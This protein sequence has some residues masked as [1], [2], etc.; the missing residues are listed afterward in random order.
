MTERKKCLR[1][2][3]QAGFT[4]TETLLAAAV[5]LI[6][7]AVS[8]VA[9]VVYRNYLR[10]TELDHAAREIYMAA[11]NRAVLLKNR[12]RLETLVVEEGEGNQLSAGDQQYVY[13]R[14]NSASQMSELLPEGTIEPALRDGKFF[15]VYEPES[16][17]VT[18]VFFAGQSV[19]EEFDSEYY[20]RERAAS[21]RQRMRQTPMVGYYGGE[22]AAGGDAVTLRTPVINIM[23]EETLRAEI[24]WWIPQTLRGEKEDIR[25]IVTL[26]YGGESV[27]LS[28]RFS[29]GDSS[30][31]VSVSSE[32]G[33]VYIT[34]SST[35]LLDSLKEGQQFKDLGEAGGSGEWSDLGNDFTITAKVV[36]E[37]S[38][39]EN[40]RQVNG[41]EKSAKNNSLFAETSTAGTARV[42]NIRHLQNLHPGFS[43]AGPEK[44]RAVQTEDIRNVTLPGSG[45]GK[46]I[47]NFQ[48]IVNENLT[49]YNGGACKIQ[50]LYIDCAAEPGVGLFGRFGRG[51]M[52]YLEH[53]RLVN[54]VVRGEG[55]AAAGALC[56]AAENVFFTD[57]QVYWEIDSDAESDLQYRLGSTSEEKGYLLPAYQ[58]SGE[59]AGGLVGAGRNCGIWRCLA[60]TTVKGKK[61]AGGLVGR[62]REI[63]VVDSYADCYLTGKDAAGLIGMAEGTSNS[64]SGSYTAGFISVN[65]AGR[66]AGLYLSESPDAAA[67]SV[68]GSYAAM[69]YSSDGRTGRSAALNDNRFPL[70]NDMN[71]GHNGYTKTWY[72]F[73]PY[74]NGGEDTPWGDMSLDYE[75]LSLAKAQAG[76]G[77]PL[78]MEALFGSH[79]FEQIGV[80]R[81]HPC[82][83]QGDLSLD[84][85]PY[86]A[87]SGMEHYGDWNGLFRSGGLVYWE[88]YA[89]DDGDVGIYGGG[90]DTLKDS[91]AM[92]RDDGY[93]VTL[94][95]D[96]LGA[97]DSVKITFQYGEGGQEQIICRRQDLREIRVPAD[98][99]E[100]TYYLAKLPDHLICMEDAS[101]DFYRRLD[102]SIG[103]AAEEVHCFFNP[104]FAGTAM[105]NDGT[106]TEEDVLRRAENLTVK[107]RS[108]RHLY[109]LSRH[110]EYYAGSNQYV[111]LQ[112]LDLDYDVY[113]GYG[114]FPGRQQESIGKN[115]ADSF[116]NT[117]DG[118]SCRI[119]NV[120]LN[121]EGEYVGLFGYNRGTVRNM[122]LG[123]GTETG[124][125]SDTEKLSL[126]VTD[127]RTVYWGVLAGG[128]SGTITNCAVASD[129]MHM[130]AYG[131]SRVYAGGLVAVNYGTIMN[132]AAVWKK[133]TLEA[134][135]SDG[136][137][138]GFAGLNAGG[139]TIY[140]SYSMAALYASRARHGTVQAGGFAG[141]NGNVIRNS[142]AASSLTVSG[143][144]FAFGFCPDRTGNCYFLNN[145][146]FQYAGE[147][148]S[149]QYSDVPGGAEGQD[150]RQMTGSSLDGNTSEKLG[151][152]FAREGKRYQPEGEYE[153]WKTF[154]FP[155]VVRDG[156]NRPVHYGEWP[157]TISL[158]TLG[159]FYWEK[160][161]AY[162][163]RQEAAGQA[164]H[165]SAVRVDTDTGDVTRIDTLCREHDDGGVIESYGYGYFY[166]GDRP[167]WM[168][169]DVYR[170]E[171]LFADLE[172]QEA[173]NALKLLV[174]EE[175]TFVAC[176]SAVRN[177][178]STY[179]ILMSDNGEKPGNVWTFT[180]SA[181]VTCRF[182]L[183]P[184]FGDTVVFAGAFRNGVPLDG[185]GGDPAVP[186]TEGKPYEIRSVEQLQFI[187]WNSLDRTSSSAISYD[188]GNFCR[189]PYLCYADPR[190][191]PQGKGSRTD[192]AYWK[193]SHDLDGRLETYNPIAAF[194]DTST[195]TSA[196]LYGWFGGVYDGDAYLIKDVN[197][198]SDSAS[199]A[200]LFG[201]TVNASLKNMV[202]YSPRGKGTVTGGGNVGWYAIGGLVGLA[203]A[204]SPDYRIEN[205]S[206]AGYTVKDEHTGHGFGGGG[207]G[208]LIGI[209]NMA[210]SECTAVTELALDFTYGDTRRH[211]RAGGI[212]GSCQQS[213]VCCYAGGSIEISE[214]AR[215]KNTRIHTGGIAGGSFMKPLTARSGIWNII[216]ITADSG[217]SNDFRYSYSYV[218]LPENMPR[219][220]KN[221]SLYLIGGKA[222]LWAGDSSSFE[223][224]YFLAELVPENM[225]EVC[226]DWIQEKGKGTIAEAEYER[227]SGEEFVSELN[228]FPVNVADRPEFRRVTADDYGIAVNGKYSLASSSFLTASD[229]PFPTICTRTQNGR[230]VNIHYGN[231]PLEGIER[232]D[233]SIPV[234]MDLFADYKEKTGG[235]EEEAA[236]AGEMVPA[237]ELVSAGAMIFVEERVFAG[238]LQEVKNG[239][240]S[241]G[242]FCEQDVLFTDGTLP[243]NDRPR[244]I[245]AG[246]ES[247]VIYA[248]GAQKEVEL[249]LSDI[250]KSKL[251]RGG[252][253]GGRFSVSVASAGNKSGGGTGNSDSGGQV[254]TAGFVPWDGETSQLSESIVCSDPDRVLKLVIIGLRQGTDKVTVTCTPDADTAEEG[255][256]V[257]TPL[258]IT[259]NV[260]AVLQYLP[261]VRKSAGGKAVGDSPAEY[262]TSGNETFLFAGKE[263][264]IGLYA[265]DEKLRPLNER[266]RQEIGEVR[267]NKVIFDTEYISR[268]EVGPAKDENGNPVREPCH[269]VL[270]VKGKRSG[271]ASLILE[272][273]YTY[274]GKRYEG[275][276]TVNVV[277]R[278]FELKGKELEIYLD[279]EKKKDYGWDNFTFLLDG[280]PV[281]VRDP[282]FGR[283]ISTNPAIA[284]VRRT[285]EGILS[286][287]GLKAGKTA[288]QLEIIFYYGSAQFTETV[289]VDVSVYHSRLSGDKDP[290]DIIPEVPDPDSGYDPDE[291]VPPDP[292]IPLDENSYP[293]ENIPPDENIYPEENI[294]PENDIVPDVNENSADAIP[295]HV[296]IFPGSRSQGIDGYGAADQAENTP[297]G[298]DDIPGGSGGSPDSHDAA[299]YNG[300]ITDGNLS[301]P[302]TVPDFQDSPFF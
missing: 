117:Y 61:T 103:N 46:R 286:V 44:T 82:N 279:E 293:S 163:E 186:G 236:A 166:T 298:C 183:S 45:G 134:N 14:E 11:Q 48:P 126:T 65:D 68:Q 194:R 47:Y 181:D 56:G 4:L 112:E 211:V 299:L 283:C 207:V 18:D 1:K 72:L 164:Y 84:R 295:N 224:C 178:D 213:I 67:A 59:C 81:S 249:Y 15:V 3:G 170:G 292:D 243:G 291:S 294:H 205:C 191:W 173:E 250:L 157:E 51:E 32:D 169:E 155:C 110:A 266:L 252:Y 301:V 55:A 88:E 185:M 156:R 225:R 241:D 91:P 73:S 302:E 87:L 107:V 220:G 39:P 154:V 35:Y 141:S 63:T 127:A 26:D 297:E 246:Q 229:Y 33:S 97:E 255:G 158:G 105:E 130:S 230:T 16:G 179:R 80:S 268:G 196:N 165:F 140:N 174:G 54:P 60:A 208:G 193:Q 221:D 261:G 284:Y 28:E 20:L 189:F 34:C 7:L 280:Q 146:N 13:Y 114:L 204:S 245:G 10:I 159:V 152:W 202:L 9:V 30:G 288:L 285:G 74:V 149:A 275:V 49:S 251:K 254:V 269:S 222:E 25:M 116:M 118:K 147:T 247:S 282:V 257:I 264:S 53:V 235:T 192:R 145:G 167:V 102:F 124:P 27:V 43:N 263:S 38:D 267:V 171:K 216:S 177:P 113:T 120:P 240:F 2:R 23:N 197:I 122:V 111:F 136:Y 24:T 96:L 206:I 148:F 287:E 139:G 239:V 99:G 94:S 125:A 108:P 195:T 75:E 71:A 232:T 121:T 256:I 86:P 172:N 273:E 234:N 248:D 227:M 276:S 19:T 270:S 144:A 92:V 190:I 133:I 277:I 37:P 242:S 162:T 57:C 89:G 142:Y 176:S 93:A 150:W 260:T 187:N 29:P 271:A 21:R 168:V 244:M 262:E 138:G 85:Y 296:D 212:A 175:Y 132:S 290:D 22:A 64:I 228:S 259:V 104:H 233:G 77:K 83:L 95:E 128:N 50:D 12:G 40:A 100:K 31:R 238:G 115:P 265:F 129:S 214:Q 198:R 70:S 274:K 79:S 66:A 5:V 76:Q 109:E 36:Y 151:G 278:T 258:E 184:L 78:T 231:W 160:E 226:K 123:D 161:S 209:C 217:A 106:L 101:R 182:T 215:S 223:G 119:V 17:S 90:I 210:L 131:Y 199:C 137:I 8:G 188:S 253:R 289:Y 237:E 6:L 41:A 98:N 69:G 218:K 201:V 281:E 200:G 135:Y 219:P 62:G 153:Q 180:N 42:G 203:A 272:Y 58:V 300:G 143:G 52:V